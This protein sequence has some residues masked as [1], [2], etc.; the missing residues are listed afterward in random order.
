MSTRPRAT[1]SGWTLERGELVDD[2]DVIGVYLST[3]TM[4][5]VIKFFLSKVVLSKNVTSLGYFFQECDVIKF[6]FAN[7]CDA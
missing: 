6:F 5:D 2:C 4:C 3:N 1:T 7:N